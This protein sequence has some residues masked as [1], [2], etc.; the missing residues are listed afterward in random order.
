[1][2]ETR[3]PRAGGSEEVTP[4]SLRSSPRGQMAF[5]QEATQSQ[6]GLPFQLGSQ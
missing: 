2:L 6:A 4:L 1:M 5:T 3:G